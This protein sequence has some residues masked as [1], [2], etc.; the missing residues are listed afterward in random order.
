MQYASLFWL[1][2]LQPRTV[3]EMSPPGLN[4]LMSFFTPLSSLP[5]LKIDMKF[6]SLFFSG[7]KIVYFWLIAQ[8]VYLYFDSWGYRRGQSMKWV[9][10]SLHGLRF[11]L[12]FH[13]HY[14]LLSSMFWR[15]SPCSSRR[16]RLFILEWPHLNNWA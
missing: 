5:F 1:L 10:C 15:G 4:G 8:Y 7:T 16:W 3:D 13:H 9:L 11:L 14:Q 12:L 6:F 2:G